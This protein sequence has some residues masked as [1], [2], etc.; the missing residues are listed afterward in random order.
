MTSSN[1]SIDLTD[2]IR[3][4]QLLI[5]GEW[6]GAADGA[7]FEVYNPATGEVISRVAEAGPAD[8]DAAVESSRRAFES[9]PWATMSP[10]E[11]SACIWR[12]G[13]LIQENTERIARVE[14]LDQ[15]MPYSLTQGSA[16][17]PPQAC[18]TTCRGGPPRSKATRFPSQPVVTSTP[19]RAV[20]RSA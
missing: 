6:R 19:T 11:R 13:D 1:E 10:M 5:D 16:S 9:G 7:V 18:S 2:E 3:L 12:L 15:G 8:V 4:T 14:T 20:S 17:R